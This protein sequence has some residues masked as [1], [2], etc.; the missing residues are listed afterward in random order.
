MTNLPVLANP[1]CPRCGKGV[2]GIKEFSVQNANF[3]HFA[4]ICT[5]CGCVI[6]TE[7]MQDDD[8]FNRIVQML[9]QVS[10][11]VGILSS[12]VERIAQVLRMKGHFV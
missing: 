2:F 1:I 5:S 12:K 4:I 6:G 8:R 9:N 11:E 3:R 7:T 10:S